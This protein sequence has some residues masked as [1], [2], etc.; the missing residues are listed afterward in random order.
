MSNKSITI[1]AIESSCDDTSAAIIKDGQVLSNL[2]A[3]QKIHRQFGGVIPEWA[4]R[5]H[6]ENIFP[7]V[8]GALRNA[9]MQKN[10]LSAVAVTIGPGLLGSLLVGT[11]FAKGLARGLGI[12]LLTVNHMEAHVLAHF[13][14]EPRPT[15]PFLCLTI[16]GGHTQ[17]VYVEN[18]LQMTVA[19]TT[20]D[21]AA[22]EAFDKIGKFVGLDYPAGPII[23][24]MAKDG[25]AIF[26]FAKP[27]VDGLNY[28]FSGFKTSVL[29]FLRDRLKEDPDFIKDNIKDICTSVQQSI[30]DIL[31]QKLE[32][33]ALKFN[34]RQ[35]AIARG[36]SANSLVRQTLTDRGI[37]LGWKTFIP[38][39]QYCTD[40]AG[41]IAMAAHFKYEAGLFASLDVSP[42]PRLPIG[43]QG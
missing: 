28:S 8:E 15:F 22:G 14:E 39:F 40:N 6:H 42:S 35:I 1:L 4:S 43:T 32:L 24:K 9:Q 16:S 10:E 41:M 2:I 27:K 21:D 17:I 29:Y 26:T 30:V 25:H 34:C 18:A 13:I 3:S 5:K 11:S 36:V 38:A 23:D 31:F 33:A 12:P 7:V 19:G 37:E 20:I